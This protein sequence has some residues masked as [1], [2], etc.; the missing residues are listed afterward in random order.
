MNFT[1]NSSNYEFTEQQNETISKLARMML[2][3]SILFM[4]SG[5]ITVLASLSPLSIIGILQ[6]A[7]L[8]VIGYSLFTASNSFKKIVE[9]TGNDI[10]NLMAALNQLYNA[11]SIQLYSIAAVIVLAVLVSL[12]S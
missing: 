5:G 9:T 2:I 11:C 10:A 4:I 7:A 1:D 3:V 8:V 6:G 12:F